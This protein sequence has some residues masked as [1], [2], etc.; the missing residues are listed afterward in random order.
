MSHTRAQKLFLAAAGTFAA[1]LAGGAAQATPT[2]STTIVLTDGNGTVPFSS[3]AP[4]LCVLA[5]DKLYGDF[6]L[7]NLPI[8]GTMS[9]Q[10]ASVDGIE[11]HQL[12]FSGLYLTD[13]TY[14]WNYEVAVA[15][16][17]ISH[18][19]IIGL[20]ADFTQTA[21]TSTLTKFTDPAGNPSLGIVET[22]IGPFVQPGSETSIVYAPGVTD[23]TIFERLVDGGTVSSVINTV[24]QIVMPSTVPEP[25]TL[26]LLGAGLIG[27]GIVR[28]R[29]P[30]MARATA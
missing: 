3:V 11:H 14:D 26:A 12:S 6:D 24:N 15:N 2:C 16:F 20:D 4:G 22:K 19:N 29:R 8:G 7:G 28:R 21:G 30:N 18:L 5:L 17:A 13:T 23:M 1:S 25:A 10:H 27:L 9:F